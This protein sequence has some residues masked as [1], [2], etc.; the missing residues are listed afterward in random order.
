MILIVSTVAKRFL[1]WIRDK[2]T[3]AFDTLDI[4]YI[5]I[6]SK[7]VLL[8]MINLALAY[9]T[10]RVLIKNKFLKDCLALIGMKQKGCFFST[11]FMYYYRRHFML[12]IT[13]YMR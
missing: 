2:K 6:V 3:C 10:L 4:K 1:Q 12:Y 13:F 11:P 7:I 5:S 8:H 9:S